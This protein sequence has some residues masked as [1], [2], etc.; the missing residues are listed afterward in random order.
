[1]NLLKDI[2]ARES[3]VSKANCKNMD[4]EL[5]FTEG[6]GSQYDPF[7]REVCAECPVI[8]ECLWY[9][10]EMHADYGFFGGMSP[11]ERRRWRRAGKILLG[12]RGMR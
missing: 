2:G 6:T 12:D 8:E 7:I 4:T 3:W 1:M 10:N 9:A 5:F 11:E